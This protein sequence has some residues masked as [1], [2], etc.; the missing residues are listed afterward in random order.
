MDIFQVRQ[1]E[2][3]LY[4]ELLLQGDEQWNMVEAYLDR[5][6]M[7]ALRDGE[8]CAVCVVTEEAHDWIEIKNLAVAS[9]VRRKGYGRRLVAFVAERWRR[10]GA[11]LYAGTGESRAT[12]SFYEACGFRRS[13]TIPRFFIDH[14]DH[15][16]F[17]E[18]KQLIDMVYLRMPLDAPGAAP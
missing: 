1:S 5:G 4:R 9:T 13:H 10:P 8:V 18:G 2:K 17:E 7:F 16:I 15:P 14:Y 11:F 6:I 12:L 3:R